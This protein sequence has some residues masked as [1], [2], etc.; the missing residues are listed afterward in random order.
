MSSSGRAANVSTRPTANRHSVCCDLPRSRLALLTVLDAVAE[1]PDRRATVAC[2]KRFDCGAVV[3]EGFAKETSGARTFHLVETVPEQGQ[4]GVEN[5][6][7][8]RPVDP[9]MESARQL[10]AQVLHF[11]I[12][13]GVFL[14][15]ASQTARPSWAARIK[16]CTEIRAFSVRTGHGSV[17]DRRDDVTLSLGRPQ[18]LP[19]RPG[20][21]GMSDVT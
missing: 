10:L 2:L 11:S 7:L 20:E 14:R 3:L 12:L 5:R 21:D 6:R 13:A 4:E 19:G 15:A 8:G 16:E 17:V 18:R 9:E 1:V